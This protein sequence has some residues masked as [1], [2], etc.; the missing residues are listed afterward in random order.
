MKLYVHTRK[1][2]LIVFVVAIALPVLYACKDS[3][4]GKDNYHQ[5]DSQTTSIDPQNGYTQLMA[6]IYDII[7]EEYIVIF[8]EQWERQISKQIGREVDQ[9]RHRILSGHSIHENSVLNNY[10]Y[11]IKGFAAKLTEEQVK[12]LNNDPRI[13]RVSPNTFLRLGALGSNT[14]TV[15]QKT[16]AEGITSSTTNRNGNWGVIRV[17][18]PADGSGKTAWILDTGIDLTHPDLNVDTGNS[19][20]FIPGES[21]NDLNGHGTHVAGVIASTGNITG[22]EG[23]AAGAEVVAIKVCNSLGECPTNSVINGIDYISIRATSSDVVNISIW[24]GVNQDIE[25][26]IINAATSGIRFALIS[27]NASDHAIGYSPGRITHNNTWTVSAMDENDHLASF[28]NYG[29]PPVDYAAPGENILSLWRNGGTNT[30]S[31]TSMAAPHVAGI[32][33]VAGTAPATDGTIS[34]DPSSPAAPIAV[35]PSPVNVNISGPSN[36]FEGSSATFKA[37]ASGGEPPYNYQWYYRHET[38]SNW[39]SMTTGS[40]YIHTAG[41]PNGEYV[42]VVATD[43][44]MATNE[45]THYFTI[46]GWTLADEDSLITETEPADF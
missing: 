44:N 11:A 2:A 4:A 5:M 38:N 33:L 26:A 6:D 29:T 46:L 41:A 25:D 19:A 28:S 14:P 13:A 18:G 20:S 23:V 32:L 42:R 24:G 1:L 15:T 27:G 31:G 8:K 10:R 45:D 40:Q 22:I 21:A 3:I 37:S 9:L 16:Q 35:I 39:T 34:G 7:E 17:G 36:M 30:D 43:S 12:T